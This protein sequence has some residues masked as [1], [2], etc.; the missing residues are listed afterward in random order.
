MS[1]YKKSF[2]V[3]LLV[4]TLSSCQQGHNGYGQSHSNNNIFT[5]ENIGTAVG[6]AGGAWVG[7]NIGKGKGQIVGIAAGTLLGAALGKSIG[8]SLD[9][10]DI[11]RYNHTSQYALENNR[12]GNTSTWRNPDTGHYG[13]ITPTR[14]YQ[15]N[16]GSNCREYTQKIYVGNRVE[17][18]YGT[19]CRQEDGSWKIIQ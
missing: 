5:K 9:T 4:I 14:T 6:A 16:S 13:T 19:A 12:I 15:N 18:G 2:A 17:E 3:G 8:S 1:H 7:S 10:N 11:E